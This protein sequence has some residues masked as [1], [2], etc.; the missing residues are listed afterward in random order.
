MTRKEAIA[1]MVKKLENMNSGDPS[2]NEEDICDALLEILEN[3]GMLPPNVCWLTTG[4]Y[5]SA[6]ELISLAEEDY[7]ARLAWESEE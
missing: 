7:D 3:L 1:R 5:G 6:K 4:E 2:G